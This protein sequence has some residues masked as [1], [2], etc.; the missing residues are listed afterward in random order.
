MKRHVLSLLLAAAACVAA[1]GQEK[2]AIVISPHSETTDLS[3]AGDSGWP[4]QVT[5][6]AGNTITVYQPQVQRW[7]GGRLEAQAAVSVENRV[8]PQPTYGVI[9]LSA[10][11][12]VDKVA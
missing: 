1:A 9:W 5:D 8:S 6:G 3:P 12:F 10:R 2:S 7:D 4:R 11:T